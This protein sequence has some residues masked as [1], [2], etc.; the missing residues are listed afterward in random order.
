MSRHLS[1][2]APDSHRLAGRCRPV[3]AAACCLVLVLA[4]LTLLPRATCADVFTAPARYFGI[5]PQLA[6]AVSWVESSWYPWCINI[7]G[8]DYRPKSRA[9][10]ARLAE[11]ALARGKSLDVGLMQINSWWLRKWKLTPAQALDPALN[12]TLGLYIL[13]QEMRR[14]GSLWKAVGAYHSPTP[15][16]QKRYAGKVAKALADI[17]RRLAQAQQTAARGTSLAHAEQ[18]VPAALP[19]GSQAQARQKQSGQAQADRGSAGTVSGSTA[20]AQARQGNST[21]TQ[22]RRAQG[23]GR[24][25]Q[26]VSSTAN[27]PQ[28]LPARP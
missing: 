3:R 9:E 17:E 12:V 5:S 8:K 10:A 14:H 28:A 24:Q 26:R 20:Q 4:C 21:Q 27:R 18:L 15:A 19:A 16:R 22:S 1:K 7:A 2:G 23:Q 13:A 25:A 6:M 11:R